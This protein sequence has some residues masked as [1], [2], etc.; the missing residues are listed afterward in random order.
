MY[1]LHIKTVLILHIQNPSITRLIYFH[2]STGK[3]PGYLF[4]LDHLWRLDGDDLIANSD[5]TNL[6]K[7]LTIL[8]AWLLRSTS[9]ILVTEP[10][11]DAAAVSA[12]TTIDRV[13]VFF[14]KNRALK[15][16][17]QQYLNRLIETVQTDCSYTRLL[18]CIAKGCQA[19][20]QARLGKLRNLLLPFTELEP[21]GDP[22]ILLQ[23]DEL[24]KD[25][26][27]IEILEIEYFSQESQFA[28]RVQ[29]S[30][31][32]V[33]RRFLEVDED[34]FVPVTKL[35]DAAFHLGHESLIPL[36]GNLLVRRLKKLGEYS[37]AARCINH[38][39]HH[40]VGKPRLANLIV[41]D[42]LSGQT[43]PTCSNDQ[44]TSRPPGERN[45]VPDDRSRSPSPENDSSIIRLRSPHRRSGNPSDSERSPGT[46]HEA[47][48]DTQVTVFGTLNHIAK[49][50]DLQLM[51]LDKIWT[52]FPDFED[53]CWTF[54]QGDLKPHSQCSLAAYLKNR[55][56][57][58]GLMEMGISRLCC[59]ACD[60]SIAMD[61]ERLPAVL[62][63][64][65]SLQRLSQDTERR[66]DRISSDNKKPITGI[67]PKPSKQHLEI[68]NSLALL[69]VTEARGDAGAI[70]IDIKPDSM[71]VFISKNR[72]LRPKELQS[73]QQLADI[74][75]DIA[76]GTNASDQKKIMFALR[77][78]V[79]DACKQRI[80]SRLCK[81]QVLLNPEDPK[82]KAPTVSKID[83]QDLARIA[84]IFDEGQTKHILGIDND[85]TQPL[86]D[87][88]RKHWAQANRVLLR[89]GNT[90]STRQLRSLV[91]LAWHL[92]KDLLGQVIGRT[93][94]QRLK[95]LGDY[96]KVA[97]V[98]LHY[99]ES[100]QYQKAMQRI[101]FVDVLANISI[102][103]KPDKEFSG[104]SDRGSRN[105]QPRL[106]RTSDSR[107]ASPGNE[108]E[109]RDRER[110]PR[111]SKQRVTV[112]ETLKWAA[113][114]HGLP[115]LTLETVKQ[116]Y[117]TFRDQ[118]WSYGTEE[119]QKPLI[120]NSSEEEHTINFTV[121]GVFLDIQMRTEGS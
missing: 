99:A 100:P 30:W 11:D 6:D 65:E 87:R 121:T 84:E 25:P 34:S 47:R 78:C 62:V 96:F 39:A 76:Q 61:P 22:S 92:G 46:Q 16:D 82:Y 63:C 90:L 55:F 115:T 36:L 17:E 103:T 7:D 106:T 44:P 67:R 112:L 64:L 107:S 79:V 33:R 101:E 74:L 37:T 104:E 53:D 109:R 81:L 111:P 75:K 60:A 2:R 98:L 94:V 95:K 32:A 38:Y 54:R 1:V 85:Y 23:F 110:S 26:V 43:Y 72:P 15:P 49:A 21:V 13:E 41:T 102:A 4:T 3:L 9:L 48:F 18:A 42:V 120:V 88:V 117:P 28:V 19:K 10:G 50:S 57:S 52:K 113:E 45:R 93:A 56:P 12:N 14:A 73:L 70:S 105:T 66:D 27:L 71:T 86:E 77:D 97:A 118:E 5:T 20:I 35:V 114:Q 80:L 108:S 89:D 40:R 83:K 31:G 51:S 116:H 68:L 59:W 58:R 29:K 8:N 24:L 119:L 69:S 91:A